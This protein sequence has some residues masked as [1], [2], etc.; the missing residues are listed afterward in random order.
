MIL[1]P[2][3]L[4]AG[5]WLKRDDLFEQAGMRGG[6]VRTCAALVAAARAQGT[7]GIVTAG[8]RSSPQVAIVARLCRQAGLPCRAHV[9]AG[10]PGPELLSAAADGAE[11]VPHRPGYNSVIVARARDDAGD[12]GWFEI[13][14]GMECGEAVCQTAAQVANLPR[15]T[16][17][18]VV[19][20]GSGMSLAGILWGLA[21]AAFLSTILGVIIGADPRRR[22]NA[23]A[24]PMW[25]DMCEL[26]S[27]G[28]R[29]DKHVDACVGSVKM[30][31]VYEAKC[32]P[33]LRADDLLWI[34]GCREG[35]VS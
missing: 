15:G 18:I 28:R 14:F 23:F 4:H 1:T 20:V 26:I 9:P 5:I 32:V 27:S 8:A 29:Y 6:K 17:R 21:N 22:L 33:F 19:P 11:L 34:V 13:P 7:A 25:E 30:D 2:V 10:A 31:P 24:P 35:S 16:K 12:R 3:E